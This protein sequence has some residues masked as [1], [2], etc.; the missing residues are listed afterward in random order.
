MITGVMGAALLLI[1]SSRAT[2]AQVAARHGTSLRALSFED[3]L[4]LREFD[5]LA[6]S[7]DGRWAAYVT[8]ARFHADTG[9]TAEQIMVLDLHQRARA[10]TVRVSG[11]PHGLQWAPHGSTLGFLMSSAGRSRLW[12]YT[13]FDS[14]PPAPVVLTPDSLGGE[15]LAF[16]WSPTG[17]SVAYLAPEP[18]ARGAKVTDTVQAPRLVLFRDV[19]GE[20]TGP[21]S[22]TFSTD[23]TGAYVAVADLASGTT[24]VLARRV[25]SS[26]YSRTIDWSRRG[27]LLIGGL[28]IGASW[29]RQVTGGELYTLDA[30]T[31]SVRRVGP[32]SLAR[33]WPAWSPSGDRIASNEFHSFLE[34]G[35]SQ[36][37]FLL[38]VDNPENQAD[39]LM[40]PHGERG[41]LSAFS[42]QWGGDDRTLYIAN[43]ERGTVRL[44]AVDLVNQ[45]WRAITPDTLCVSRYVVARDGKTV[46][47]VLE[48]AN[49]PQELYQ[50]DPITGALSQL[51]RGAGGLLPAHL[52]HVEQF[53][54]ASSDGRFTVHG[55]LVKPPAYDST[56]RYPLIVLVHGGPGAIFTN[57]FL[58]VNFAR[59]STYIPPQLFA[60]RGY[61]VLLPN[62]RGDTSYGTAFETALHAD[63]GPGPFSD[64]NAGVSALIARG[65]VDS[66]AVGI[67]G[68][69][70]GGYLTAFAI[71]QTHRFG[72]ASINDGPTDLRTDYG[73][74]YAADATLYQ[75]Y[76]DGTPWNKPDVYAAQ[77]PITYVSRVRTPVLMRYGG[78]SS[79]HDNIRLPYML[80]QG[81]EF[82]A[83]LRDTGVPV[84]FV[85]HPDQGHGI[86]DWGL[87]EDWV[88]RNLRWFDYW[89]RHRGTNPIRAPAQ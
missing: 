24:R 65:L 12:R 5:D 54:W 70:Y 13:P 83:G 57:T 11:H 14:A 64:I 69:S 59:T 48:N 15:M 46:L 86:H 26:K 56:R 39:P 4:P 71:T 34:G 40:L 36:Q 3:L 79:T 6:V 19:P 8:S 62:P 33:L 27:V 47:A 21:T 30:H 25:I 73:V 49:Q 18:I 31:S 81:F 44:F 50:I 67:A 66:T 2:W 58:D 43:Y 32:D 9:S 22:P 60:S 1:G 35:R 87:Y 53:T 37:S 7:P 41:A 72:A 29:L 28:P 16:A 63:W 89:L 55:F 78:V 10:R 38:R 51:T 77:S 45:E 76:F 74:S 82:Y 17:D 23:S 84:E 85:L 80:A 75:F 42:P 68:S 52:G 88:T 61:L 20:L